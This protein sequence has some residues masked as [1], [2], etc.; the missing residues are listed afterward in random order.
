MIKALSALE[1]EAIVRRLEALVTSLEQEAEE[2][3]QNFAKH[4]PK[5]EDRSC[6]AAVAARV[7][8]G[9]LRGKI[10]T[11]KEMLKLLKERP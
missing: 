1:V 3:N 2:G 4:F 9:Y 10:Y 8:I 5:A 6:P 7:Q 11:Y